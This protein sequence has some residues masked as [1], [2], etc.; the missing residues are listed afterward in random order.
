M[1]KPPT[2][3]AAEVCKGLPLEKEALGLLEERMLPRPYLDLLIEKKQYPDA[4]RFMAAAMPRGEAIWWGCLC[5]RQVYGPEPPAPAQ[6]ALTAT[7]KWLA[8]PT[9]DNRMAAFAAAEAAEFN[10]PAGLIGFAV[11]Q[12]GQSLGAPEAPPVPPPEH[13]AAVAVGNA[14]IL[15]AVIAGPRKAPETYHSFFTLGFDVAAGKNRWKSAE[16]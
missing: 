7:E 13:G 16:K 11:L 6:V 15:A 14:V 12:S 9:D 8:D 4:A 3:T 10:N 2:K 5:A 1:S